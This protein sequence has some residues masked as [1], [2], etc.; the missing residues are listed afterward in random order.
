M[1]KMTRS[2]LGKKIAKGQDV[3]KKGKNFEDVAEKAAEKYGSA[4]AGRR[5]AASAMWKT[6]TRRGK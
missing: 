4:E 5:V 2:E 1:K 3:G 6:L